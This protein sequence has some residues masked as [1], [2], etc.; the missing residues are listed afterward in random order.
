LLGN[1]EELLTAFKVEIAL[2]DGKGI[3]RV[4]I[5]ESRKRGE[6]LLVF[7]CFRKTGLRPKN[8]CPGNTS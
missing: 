4:L 5:R 2:E 1:L 3:H 6:I 8:D 7:F